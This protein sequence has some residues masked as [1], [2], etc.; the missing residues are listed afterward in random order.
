MTGVQLA[1]TATW[2]RRLHNRFGKIEGAISN[3]AEREFKAALDDCLK[4][5]EA[6]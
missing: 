4:M 1:P 3:G 2:F 5:G 6:K